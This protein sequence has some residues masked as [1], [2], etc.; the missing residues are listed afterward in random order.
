[1]SQTAVADGAG[2]RSPMTGV[3]AALTTVVTLLFLAPV[4][5][6][7]PEATLGALVFVAAIGLVDIDK[8]RRI[9]AAD[10]RDGILAVLAALGVAAMGALDGILVAVLISVLTLLYETSRRPVEVVNLVARQA[11]PLEP[12]PAGLL[13]LHPVSEIYFANVEHLRREILEAI[14]DSPT[15]PRV[16]LL[17]ATSVAVFEYSAHQALRQLIE[18]V[19]ARGIVVWE[20]ERPGEAADA[21]D[22]YRAAHGQEA[23]RQFPTVEAAVSA[24]LSEFAPNER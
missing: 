12:V 14:A 6:D 24:Y 13:V 7:L 17:D 3:I 20:A 11:S 16:V 5:S 9:F 2:A 1:M 21:A 10:R 19:E 18:D 15:P 23:V 8:V 4:F 22:R